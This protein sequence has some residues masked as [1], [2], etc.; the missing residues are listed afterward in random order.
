[1]IK[2]GDVGYVRELLK[3]ISQSLDRVEKGSN[4]EQGYLEEK[5]LKLKLWVVG[6]G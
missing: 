5:V 4:V 1:M 3:S 6:Y 2:K